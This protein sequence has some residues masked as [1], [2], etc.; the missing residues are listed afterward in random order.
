MEQFSIQNL[1]L[2]VSEQFNYV[3]VLLD[4]QTRSEQFAASLNDASFH[5]LL[6]KYNVKN[7]LL[8]CGKMW[9]F[10]IP[11]MSEYIDYDF[12]AAM[13]GI[14][15]EK[16]SVV[17]NEEIFSMMSGIFQGV[18]NRHAENP[19]EIRFF[20]TTSFYNSFESVNWF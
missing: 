12:A 18:Q 4:E 6:Q 17:I 20:D 14:G 16:I 1:T 19:P 13:N 11:D 15:V 5:A 10:S 3:W 2:R 8:D 7:I 9:V